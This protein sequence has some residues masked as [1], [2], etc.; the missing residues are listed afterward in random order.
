[1]DRTRAERVA[2]AA[3]TVA[4]HHVAQHEAPAPGAYRLTWLA[5]MF[6]FAGFY[7]LLA[8]LPRYLELAGFADWQIGLVL[9]AFG[10]ASLV[11]RPVAGVAVDR[12]G[13]RRVMLAGAGALVAG[14][15]LF[16]L[17]S[18][19]ALLFALR[20]LQAAGYV[21][22]TTAGTAL[23]VL[24]TR[25]AER[26]RR[27]ALFG[28]AA[29]LSITLT[30]AAVS[31]LLE[32]APL[33][34]G[35]LVSCALALLSGLLALGVQSP[36]P[37]PAARVAASGLALVLPRELRL[38][39]IV[40]GLFGAGFAAF[41]Q[42]APLLADRRG[43]SA[44]LLYAIYGAGI[45]LTRLVSGGW[46]DRAGI[47]RIL[48]LASLLMCA[49]L[50]LAALATG[51]LLLGISALLLSIGSG[52][53]HPALIA[54]HAALLPGAPGRASAAFYIGFDLGIGLGSWLFGA[55]LQLGGLTALYSVAAAIVLVP[56]AF[57]TAL[58]RGR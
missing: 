26:G 22:F 15:G 35:F 48:A 2:D 4:E 40:A 49:G 20:V 37:T 19:L 11:G 10:V 25:P 9:G 47:A 36:A 43:V 32:Q 44:G 1:M 18:S 21:A 13:A 17:T 57:L 39:M 46:V 30:P 38:P 3:N 14:S 54:H 24:L 28:I 16:A 42:F 41:F 5:T 29:N 53:F 55:M 33:I 8:P 27:L 34:S 6:F 56:L 7:A 51:P 23:V 52:L 58:S 12:W 31:L 50:G 45:M